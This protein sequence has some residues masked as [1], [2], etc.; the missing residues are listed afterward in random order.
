MPICCTYNVQRGTV[1]VIFSIAIIIYHSDSH[2]FVRG[3]CDAIIDG[4]WR[5]LR[6]IHVDCCMVGR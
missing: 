5:C 1:D 4:R 3:F 2:Q 6:I